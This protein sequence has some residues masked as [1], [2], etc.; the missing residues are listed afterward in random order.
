MGRGLKEAYECEASK[1]K[2]YMRVE[3]H[4]GGEGNF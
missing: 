1:Y 4:I 2:G 3:L